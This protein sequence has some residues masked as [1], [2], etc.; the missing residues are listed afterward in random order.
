MAEVD[1][2]PKIRGDNCG[3]TVEKNVRGSHSSRSFHKPDTWG[4]LN[5]VGGR[6]TDAYGGKDKLALADLCQP[7]A[8]GALD[9]AAAA[10][11]ELRGE[12]SI[13]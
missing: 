2:I 10:L 3:L 7:C 1:I 8:N 13:G 4:S 11:K 5:A 9:A 6:N 12:K